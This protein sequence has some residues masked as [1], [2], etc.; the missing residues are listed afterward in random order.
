MNEW[1][2]ESISKKW[3]LLDLGFISLNETRKLRQ[4]LHAVPSYNIM[5]EQLAILWDNYVPGDFLRL[6][7]IA[8]AEKKMLSKGKPSP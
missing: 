3:I 5:L 7:S 6:V 8:N 1:I 4:N 2:V